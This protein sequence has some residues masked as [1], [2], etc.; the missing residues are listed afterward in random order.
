MLGMGVS[1]VDLKGG[2]ENPG[3]KKNVYSL[4]QNALFNTGYQTF[5]LNLK[6][7][8]VVHRMFQSGHSLSFFLQVWF[9]KISGAGLY[10]SFWIVNILEIEPVEMCKPAVPA[11]DRKI[12]ATDRD[13]VGAAH[14]A[15]PA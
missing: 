8:G 2:M 4:Y 10:W 1:G 5:S 6:E 11:P 7:T 12:P 15:L 14:L 13:I 3:T 9:P